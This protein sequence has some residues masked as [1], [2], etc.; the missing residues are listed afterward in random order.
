MQLRQCSAQRRRKVPPVKTTTGFSSCLTL[1]LSVAH[2]VPLQFFLHVSSRAE[3]A[4]TQVCRCAFSVTE[5]HSTRHTVSTSAWQ[6]ILMKRS[7]DSAHFTTKSSAAT[8]ISPLVPQ[9]PVLLRNS[10]IYADNKIRYT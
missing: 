7:S 10:C 1:L 5:R 3:L 8:T 9:L 6:D 2:G 4:R